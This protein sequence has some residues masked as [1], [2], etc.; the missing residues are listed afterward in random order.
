MVQPYFS[1]TRQEKFDQFLKFIGTGRASSDI[2]EILPAAI[3]GK[4]D[5]LFIENRSDI[6]GIY[7]PSA[8]DLI[9]QNTHRVPNVSLMNLVAMK[10][11]KKG[12][13]VYLFEKKDAPDVSSNINALFRY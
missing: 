3:E 5:T 10:A 7:N 4:V 6:F 1:K 8:Q 11:L 9:I 12:G 2:T 13:T